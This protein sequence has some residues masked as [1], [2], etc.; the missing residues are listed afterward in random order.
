[1]L[2]SELL[3]KGLKEK[4]G[5]TVTLVNPAIGGTTLSQNLV[6][7]PRWLREAP[8]P[9]LVTVW[10]GFSDWDS[11]VRGPRFREYLTLAVDRIRA[12]TGGLC[13]ILLLTTC[14]AFSRWD[15]MKALEQAVLEVAQEKWTG[16]AD[17]AGEFHRAGSPERAMEEGYW[18]W[19]K[20]H[21]GTNG[22]KV[23]AE[24]ILREIERE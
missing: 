5:S 22:H 16:L 23:A 9:D 24:T 20:T 8:N 14:P 1:M 4:Y 21:L 7:M 13:D 17:V 15:S 3:A 10:F 19:D 18:A 2:W 11:G 6:L 12:R